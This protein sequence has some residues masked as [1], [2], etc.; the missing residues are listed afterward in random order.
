M[1]IPMPFDRWERIPRHPDWKYE[2][3]DGAAQLSY[4]P[5]PLFLRRGTGAP[6]QVGRSHDVRLLHGPDD[7]VREFLA[8]FWRVEDPFRTIEDP[9][10]WIDKELERSFGR[11]AEPGGA[12]AEEDGEMVGAVL[13]ER[14]HR[15]DTWPC[16]TWLAVRRG[17]RCDGVATALLAAVATAL[18]GAGVAQLDSHASPGNRASI[19]WHW[20]SGFAALPDPYAAYS[21]DSRHR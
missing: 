21:S 16:L 10:K 12:V 2:Y 5:K 11:L 15:D 17:F 19:A 4:R 1:D 13:V 6:V 18:D 20:R 3:A 9:D 7:R 8:G 14:P